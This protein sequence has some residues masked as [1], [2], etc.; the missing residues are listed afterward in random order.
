MSVST[1]S[2]YKFEPDMPTKRYGKYMSKIGAARKIQT[3]YRRF[4]QTSQ[5]QRDLGKVVRSYRKAN[6]Y[7]I[8]PSSGRTVTFWR[9]TELNLLLNQS[10]GFDTYGKNVNFGF[11]L[12]RIIGYV[13]GVFRYSIAVPNFSDFQSLFDYYMINAVK[14]QMFYSKT[15]AENTTTTTTGMPIF[16]IAN[17]FDDIQESMTLFTMME[18]VGARH[19]QFQADNQKGITQ[20]IKPKPTSVMTQTDV[21]TGALSVSNSGIPFGSTWLDTANSNIVHNGVKF[22]YDNQGLTT[23]V[24]MGCITFVFDVEYVFKGYR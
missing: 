18:R 20:Y 13:D 15:V 21:L 14:I 8:Q 16:I 24:A 7:Q 12:G 11:S 1:G 22:Y 19:V 23:S 9:K 4:K 3:A 10:T 2:L 6:P 5:D 17:D